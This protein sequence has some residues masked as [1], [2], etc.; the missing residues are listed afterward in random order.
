MR[1]NAEYP[2]LTPADVNPRG[3]QGDCTGEQACRPRII[4][5]PADRAA[6]P[7]D[8]QIQRQRVLLG[9]ATRQR[10]LATPG[11]AGAALRGLRGPCS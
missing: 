1:S 7:V 2:Q 5:P 8:V 9:V 6:Q 4:A 11:R 3:G 10:E